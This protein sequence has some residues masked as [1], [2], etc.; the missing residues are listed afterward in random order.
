MYV[1]M[2]DLDI[3]VYIRVVVEPCLEP[4][5]TDKLAYTHTYIYTYIYTYT[6]THIIRIYIYV[7]KYV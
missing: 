2:L 5:R 4:W 6:H 7:Y 3:C 1:Y